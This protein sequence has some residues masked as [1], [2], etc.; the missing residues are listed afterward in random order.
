MS[1]RIMAPRMDMVKQLL[2]NHCRHGEDLV[3]Q[4]DPQLYGLKT[5]VLEYSLCSQLEKRLGHGKVV[6]RSS[7]G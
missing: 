5:T 7:L 2:E 1:S 4:A 6:N 3:L